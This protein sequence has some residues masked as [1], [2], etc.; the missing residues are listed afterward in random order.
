M[1]RYWPIAVLV[2][3]FAAFFAA[4][5]HEHLT[6]E[7]F[8]DHGMAIKAWVAEN[9][10]LAPLAFMA[11]YAV[12]VAFSLPGGLVLS[13]AGGFLF[14][15][16]YGTALI[17][18]GATVGAV[19]V[20]LACRT[21][22]GVALRERA[23]PWFAKLEGGFNDNAFSYLL[24]LRLVPLF[25]FFVVNIVPAFLGVPLST[26]AVTTLI[27]IVPGTVVFAAFGASLD[28]IIA[29]GGAIDASTVLSPEI[30][31]ALIGLAVMSLLPVAYKAVKRRRSGEAA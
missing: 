27:G 28:M 15:I 18:V 11:A 8:R 26:Y 2:A 17:V 1:K 4:G 19:A 29:D 31:T 12:A 13:I 14:G 5:L 21:S 24:V 9:A 22:L 10:I 6:L 23:G 3:G 7:V 25:P 30:M 16:V 20:F